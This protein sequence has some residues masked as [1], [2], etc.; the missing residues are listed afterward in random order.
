LA[1]TSIDS[2]DRS[3]PISTSSA[4]IGTCCC[5]RSAGWPPDASPRCC[6]EAAHA[7]APRPG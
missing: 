1:R 2:S 4:S 7:P 5:R 6:C 3:T